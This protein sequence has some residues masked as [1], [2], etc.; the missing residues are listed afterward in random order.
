MTARQVFWHTAEVVA[1]L[2]T[3]VILIAFGGLFTAV[4]AW[5]ARAPDHALPNWCVFGLALGAC[6]SVGL[7]L[8]DRRE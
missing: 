2:L 3:S 1:T 4:F 5:L 6:V 8:W 7:W